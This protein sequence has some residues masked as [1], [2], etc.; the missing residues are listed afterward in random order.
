MA[1]LELTDETFDEVVNASD[2]PVLVEFSARWRGPCA[3]FAPVLERVA[4][5]EQGRLVVATLDVDDHPVT[6]RRHD[7]MAIPTVVL[8][9]DGQPRRRLVGARG[10]HQLLE[11]IA[12]L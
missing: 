2:V 7:V 1:V 3:R 12:E 6:Y 11:E 5:E 4:E 9:V 10:R 8:F